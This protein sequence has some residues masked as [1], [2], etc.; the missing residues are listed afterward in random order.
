MRRSSRGA[1]VGGESCGD[2]PQSD[3]LRCPT[4]GVPRAY[5]THYKHSWRG[6]VQKST[7][8]V[9][10]CLDLLDNV[11]AT[12]TKTGRNCGEVRAFGAEWLTPG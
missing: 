8:R 7:H 5:A 3:C 2:L 4:A 10:Q 12:I 11:D 1:Q 6:A 9:A